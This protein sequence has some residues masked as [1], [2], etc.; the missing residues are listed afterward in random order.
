MVKIAA[1]LVIV[2]GLLGAVAYVFLKPTSPE[3]ATPPA[4]H[5]E[6]APTPVPPAVPPDKTPP[7]PVQLPVKEPPP[8]LPPAE[9]KPQANTMDPSV[10]AAP[11]SRPQTPRAPKAKPME[12][13][14]APVELDRPSSPQES[15]VPKPQQRQ[16]EQEIFSCGD[17]P[18]VLRLVCGLEGKDVIRK[19]APDLKAWNNDIPGCKRNSSPSI[20]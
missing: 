17:L 8:P 6:S 18:F 16:D 15:T 10:K 9:N 7:P 4:A 19:C 5:T 14:S 13:R 11:P 3:T 20:N 12:P 1:T 2:L